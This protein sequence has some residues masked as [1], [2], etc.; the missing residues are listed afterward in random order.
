[1]MMTPHTITI[2]NR[3][4]GKYYKK[5]LK[6]V[7]WYG[8][9]SINISGKG[10]VES[11]NINIVIT[12]KNLDDYVNYKDFDGDEKK[13]TVQKDSRI[14]LDEGPDIESLNDL[15]DSY[16]QITI[17]SYDENIVGSPLDNVLIV[18]KP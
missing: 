1:M 14:V 9:D 15:D 13:Y 8:T 18:G 5:I 17:F 11:G 7:Y 12:K 6:D 2:Y 16:R 4:R 10:I 3:Y